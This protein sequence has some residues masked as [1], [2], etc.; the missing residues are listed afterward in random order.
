MQKVDAM[1]NKTDMQ[2][3]RYLTAVLLGCLLLAAMICYGQ[4][5]G[6]T[7]ILAVSL[8]AFLLFTVWACDKKMILPVLL[9]F[10]PWSPLLKLHYGG[11]SFF[12]IALLVSCVFFL[13]KNKLSLGVYQVILT[14]ALMVVTL[15]AKAVQGN[16]IANNYLY[17][18]IMLLL[19]PCITKGSGQITSF[20]DLT[21][22]F[23][24]GII[25]AALSA[26]Q[27]SGYPNISQY[28]KVDSYLSIT[29]LSGYYLDPNFYSAHITACMAGVQLLLSREKDR[30]RQLI[31]I[32]AAVILIYCGLLSASKS[33]IIIA[34]GLFLVWI[35]ILLEK[36]NYGS[37]RFR[38]LMGLLCAGG[39]ILSSS[40]FRELFQILDDRFAYASNVSEL[41]TRRTDIWARYIGEFSRNGLLTLLGEGYTAV[42][43]G[44]KASHNTIVQ[45][46]YQ[47]GVLGIPLICAWLSCSIKNIFEDTTRARIDW[48]SVILMCVGVVLPWMSLDILFFD[49]FLLLPV[50]A[51]LGTAYFMDGSDCILTLPR[52]H[53]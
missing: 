8:F 40:A 39:I 11:I 28:I 12:T 50:Y 5:K 35:P 34:A 3:N 30:I 31:L 18:F 24:C 37:S 4:I 20:W 23:S 36:N 44:D 42:N 7:I 33:F 47:F 16:S 25:T 6:S 10:L 15:T 21:L 2:S 9:F 27:V 45:G 14:A 32:V 51:A 49:E 13:V 17:F 29:R 46:V 41:T 22:L 19:F 1:K 38:L 52:Q 48:K 43:M 53:F 26:K